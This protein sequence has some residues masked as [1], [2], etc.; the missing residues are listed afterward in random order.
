MY[1]KIRR[2]LDIYVFGQK[3]I[4]RIHLHGD[5]C[6]VYTKTFS[7]K[8]LHAIVIINERPR[9]FHVTATPCARSRDVFSDV[10]QKPV[11]ANK[12]KQFVWTD[13]EAQLLLAVT[14]GYKIKHLVEGTRD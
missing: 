13:D 8:T 3:R 4:L 7:P 9:E 2:R 1:K 10:P 14:Q 12:K 6:G 5:K 11:A